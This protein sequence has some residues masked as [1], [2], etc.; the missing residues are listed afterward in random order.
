MRQAVGAFV[1]GA[2]VCACLLA[3][4]QTPPRYIVDKDVTI[5]LDDGATLCAMVVRPPGA[6]RRPAALEFTIYVSPEQDLTRLEYAAGRGYAGIMVYARGKSCSPDTIAPY[7]HDGHDANGAIDWISKQPWSDGQVGMMGGSY[8]GF[9]QWAAAKFA[10]PHLKTIVPIVP[11]NPG[12]GLPMQNNVFLLA[13]YAWIYYVTDNKTLDDATYNDPKWRTLP[14]RWYQSGRSYRDVDVVAGMPNPWLRKWLQHPSYDGYW[15][16]MSPYRGDYAR[17]RIPVLTIDGY[18]GDST[19]IGYFNDFQKYNRAAQTYLVAGPWD[20]FGSQR[21]RKPDVVRGYRIDPVAHI[22][23]WKLTFDWFDFVMRGKPRPP[24]VRNRV[25]YEVMGANAW[26]HAPSLDAMG[27]PERFYPTTGHVS[28]RFYL[29]S[30]MP[31]AGLGALHQVVNLADRKTMNNDSYPSPIL[32]RE[33]DLS[34]GCNFLTPPFP[35]PEE[36]SGLDGVVR[37]RVNARDLDVGLAL[38]EMLPD[39]RLFQLTYDTERASYGSDMSARRLLT[40]G[41]EATVPFDQDDLFSR[42]IGKGS[43]LLLTLNVNKNPFAEINYGTGGD[44]ATESLDD[45]RA[46]MQVDW[47]TSSYIRL[48]LRDPRSQT[49]AVPGRAEGEGRGGR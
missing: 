47:L 12:N 32:D 5:H 17:I 37:L 39:G 31:P 45:A 22:D 2:V 3:T 23:A 26:R 48:R 44:V 43:R 14:M 25:N 11:N 13:N 29:L 24:L 38:Y 18:Y 27:T 15:Q 4:A 1:L 8:D 6:A 41:K 34:N 21:R 28:R 33:P 19:A 49:A 30:P 9:T 42:L 20:H 16:S 36:V 35:R 40:P 10:N 46:P 7:E